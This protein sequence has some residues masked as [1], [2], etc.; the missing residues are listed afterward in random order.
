M[1]FTQTKA[2]RPVSN[3]NSATFTIGDLLASNLA[4]AITSACQRNDANLRNHGD[5]GVPPPTALNQNPLVRGY[6]SPIKLWS[7]D[8]LAHLIEAALE[9]RIDLGDVNAK[10]IDE[11]LRIQWKTVDLD[12][13]QYYNGKSQE[14]KHRYLAQMQQHISV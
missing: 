1:G 3:T 14:D 4:L 13:V 12:I 2:A 9:A 6:C 8:I 7:R 5:P 11:M 10:T